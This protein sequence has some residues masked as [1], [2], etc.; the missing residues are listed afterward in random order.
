MPGGS[1][2]PAPQGEG[3][4][5]PCVSPHLAGLDLHLYYKTVTC[6]SWSE[7]VGPQVTQGLWNLCLVFEVRQAC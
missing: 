1:Y 7:A 6:S 2:A 3:R 4:E 5:A